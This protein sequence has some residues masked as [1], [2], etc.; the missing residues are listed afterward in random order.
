VFSAA[1]LAAIEEDLGVRLTDHFDL[2]AGTSTGGIIALGLGLGLSPADILS[3]YIEHGPS[4]FRNPMRLRSAL[5]WF[6][7]STNRQRSKRRS[8]PS[9]AIARSARARS[10]L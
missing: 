4:I 5:W 8:G 2:I 9:S 6:G 3:F 1:I 10:A 7:A